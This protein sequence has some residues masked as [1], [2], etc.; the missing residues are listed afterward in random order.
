[1]RQTIKKENVL[2]HTK[3]G[4]GL[5]RCLI[6]L[7]KRECE[8]ISPLKQL[9]ASLQYEPSYQSGYAGSTA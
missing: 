1:M 7:L 9:H 6:L 8:I 5:V 4:I 2:W 3:K